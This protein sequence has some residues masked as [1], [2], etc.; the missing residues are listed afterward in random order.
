MKS[1]SKLI[2]TLILAF[3]INSVSKLILILILAFAM[4]SVLK[5]IFEIYPQ[6]GTYSLPTHRRGAH[7]KFFQ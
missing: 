7:K 6:T 4:N 2:F 5:S 3:A 1:V